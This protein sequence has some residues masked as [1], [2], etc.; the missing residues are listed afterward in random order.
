MEKQQLQIQTTNKH[1]QILTK[2]KVYTDY[3]HVDCLS[4]GNL[5]N[6]NVFPSKE[7]KWANMLEASLHDNC[8]QMDINSLTVTNMVIEQTSNLWS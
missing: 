8:C 6:E 3:Y 5:W 7:L 2:E 1:Y 4:V